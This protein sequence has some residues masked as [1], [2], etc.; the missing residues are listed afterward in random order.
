MVVNDPI[1]DML[2]RIRNAQIARHDSV[3]IPASNMKKA[4]AKILLDEGYV[5]SV[6]NIADG[7][8]G[9]Q[10]D[11]YIAGDLLDLLLAF[12]AAFFLHAF[13]RGNRDGQQLHDNGS[14]DVR[15]NTHGHDG[16]LTEGRTRHHV[17]QAQHI[18]GFR[19]LLH[20]S[21]IQAGNGDNADQ[22]ENQQH[23][24]RVEHLFTELGNPPY[25]A[26]SLPHR[27]FTS[28]FPPIASIFSFADSVTLSTETVSFFCSSPPPRT[29]TPSMAFLIRPFS[30]SA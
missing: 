6:E 29:F 11:G 15:R 16:H 19:S 13:Q 25:I 9:S 28:T 14:V 23:E 26:E 27:Y 1:A 5:K 2:T 17:H 8:Q 10:A 21:R 7:L 24:E 12:F 20:H 18:I 22:T 3:T 4:I 30:I